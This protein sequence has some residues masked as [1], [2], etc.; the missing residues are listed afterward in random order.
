VGEEL[1]L[2]PDEEWAKS[3]RGSDA[4]RGRNGLGRHFWLYFVLPIVVLTGTVDVL[5]ILGWTSSGVAGPVDAV[6]YSAAV[7]VALV[8]SPPLFLSIARSNKG[9]ILKL[10][11]IAL[12]LL[13]IWSAVSLTY[14][15]VWS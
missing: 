8:A 9:I 4:T 3:T 5:H 12:T 1:G 13:A 6:L 7:V 15:A 2:L 11:V 10:L 14:N